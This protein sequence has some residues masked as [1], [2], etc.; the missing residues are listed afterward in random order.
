MKHPRTLTLCLTAAV[1]AVAALAFASLGASAAW[2]KEK[3]PA[4]GQCE[5]APT[6]EGLYGDPNCVEPVKKVFG[7]TNGSYEWYPLSEENTHGSKL[8][9]GESDGPQPVSEA[10][11]TL[12]GGKQIKCEGLVPETQI[13][14]NGAHVI[15]AAPYFEFGGCA[16][17]GTTFSGETRCDSTDAQTYGGIGS[18]DEYSRIFEGEPGD[19]IGTMSFIKGKNSS[20]PEVGIVYK[21]ENPGERFLQQIVCEDNGES[22]SLLVGGHK[23][24]E[25]LT[26]GI[27]P[28]N[29]MTREYTATFKQTAGV[30]GPAELEGHATK[31]LQAQVNSGAWE[32]IGFE[33]TMAFPEVGS[34]SGSAYNHKRDELELKATP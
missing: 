10:T 30:Q 13:V 21:T 17:G 31:P 15:K 12:A 29:T 20:E 1:A 5:P 25:Q 33:A 9:Y 3:L 2:A 7:K 28:V 19:W 14:L 23:K 32:T 27:T 8:N 11:I 16:P 34:E 26:M 22:L 6:H 4:W 24:G 18:V